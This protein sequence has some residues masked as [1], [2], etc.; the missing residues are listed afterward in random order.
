MFMDSQNSKKRGNSSTGI[1]IYS[2]IIFK[3]STQVKLKYLNAH[4]KTFKKFIKN[5]FKVLGPTYHDDFEFQKY[6]IF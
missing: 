5:E 2:R 1:E 4:I 6:S 3:R